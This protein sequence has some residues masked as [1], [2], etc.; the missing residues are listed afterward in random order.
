VVAIANLDHK[1]AVDLLSATP[2]LATA[3][4]AR[5]DE[6]FLAERL[7]QLCEG[8][9]ALHA[10]GFSYDP[11]MARDLITRG[12]DIRARNRRGAEPLHAA[13]IGDP[14]SASWNPAC[15]RNVILY[16]IEAGADPNAAA[17]G[18]VTPLHRAI[19]NRSSAA[20]EA[21]LRAGADPRLP[22]DRGSTACDLAHWTTGRSGT[23][24]AAARAEQRIIIELLE[25][26]TGR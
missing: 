15:Q 24:S 8:D 13:V 16:L 5:P 7:A 10:A 9:T 21:L 11:D 14:G 26:S 3:S 4:L 19:R 12:A 17:A 2:S 6:F 25:I 23:G 22:N 20:V 1:A 18:G